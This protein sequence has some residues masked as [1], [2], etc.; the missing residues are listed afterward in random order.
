MDVGDQVYHRA[1][2]DSKRCIGL[3]EIVEENK[4]NFKVC[5][6]DGFEGW[7]KTSELLLGFEG[8]KIGDAVI[9]KREANL[10]NPHIGKVIN[11]DENYNPENTDIEVE[12][13]DGIEEFYS[14][15]ELVLYNPNLSENLFAVGDTVY[16]KDYE[17]ET[18][19][20]PKGVIAEICGD[21]AVIFWSDSFT[22][23][24]DLL[25]ISKEDI[26]DKVCFSVSDCVRH[27][28][29]VEDTNYIG[30]V[31]SVSNMIQVMWPDNNKCSYDHSD[32]ILVKNAEPSNENKLEDMKSLLAEVCDTYVFYKLCKDDRV[33][34]S[35]KAIYDKFK[36]KEMKVLALYEEALNDKS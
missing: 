23:E 13:S 2:R 27:N 20:G 26:S 25:D 14:A 29:S 16:S 8:I 24:E 35:T 21:K 36:D 22:S 10:E 18:G 19:T 32:L 9:L 17:D 28:S 33:P 12:W 1:F 7:Y 30:K 3:G 15:H 34:N 4:G 11:I 6:P 5:W 31:I